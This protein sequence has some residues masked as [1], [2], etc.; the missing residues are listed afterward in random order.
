MLSI[1]NFDP[2]PILDKIK[3]AKKS[4]K[5]VEDD[6]NKFKQTLFE[7]ESD[8]AIQLA[9][10]LVRDDE[11][12]RFINS[13]VKEV[14][15][16]LLEHLNK[17]VLPVLFRFHLYQAIAKT[18][19]FNTQFYVDFIQR[20][21]ITEDYVKVVFEKRKLSVVINPEKFDLYD[22]GT[23]IIKTRQALNIGKTPKHIATALWYKYYASAREGHRVIRK[24]KV[25]DKKTKT[26]HEVEVDVTE[27]Y[28]QKYYETIKKRISF[29]S[30]DTIPFFEILQRG[31]SNVKLI[32]DR[33]A[34]PYPAYDGYD[35]LGKV[36]ESIENEIRQA[37][38]AYKDYLTEK[39]PKVFVEFDPSVSEADYKQIFSDLVEKGV[40]SE[41]QL[42]L[43]RF[44][45]LSSSY[46]INGIKRK[47]IALGYTNVSVE[48]LP[49]KKSGFTLR[50]KMPDGKFASWRTR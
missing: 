38:I 45:S 25:Y 47:M 42:R 44:K 10:E 30:R 8:T 49:T 21:R 14:I 40:I 48:I 37:E 43:L 36:K 4:L 15:N 28:I 12:K 29:M 6:F 34:K 2:N 1:D 50:V 32:S 27:Q 20:F 23:A 19:E 3:S 35:I 9:S 39:F 26:Y 24:K 5:R 11:I 17:K 22:Y 13:N 41:N 16:R 33:G 46:I 7:Q 18:R 31:S